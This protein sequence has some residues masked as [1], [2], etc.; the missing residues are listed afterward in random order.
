MGDYT[1]KGQFEAR[2]PTEDVMRWLNS[3]EGI[4]GWWSDSVEGSASSRGDQFTVGFPTT[5]VPFELEVVEISDGAVSWY[6]P[7]NP[8]W[9]KETTIR[10]DLSTSDDGVTSIMFTHG[11][12]EPDDPI[13]PAITPAWVRFVDNLVR[14]AESGEASPAVTN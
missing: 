12:F 7:E 8:P 4:S 9:W 5:D 1:I 6:V 13:I 11:G 10:F 3:P 2:C 14:V